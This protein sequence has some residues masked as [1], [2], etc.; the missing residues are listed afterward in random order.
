MDSVKVKNAIKK[1]ISERNGIKLSE[2]EQLDSLK[3]VVLEGTLQI[4]RLVEE[5]V[6]NYEVARVEYCARGEDTP[7]YF[8]MPAGGSVYLDGC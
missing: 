4:P 7:H 8:L 5:L 3:P 6:S 1:E 2:L